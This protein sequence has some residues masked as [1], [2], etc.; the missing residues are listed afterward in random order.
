[1]TKYIISMADIPAEGREFLFSEQE[2]WLEP[3]KDYHIEAKTKTPVEGRLTVLP[4]GPKSC[5]VRGQ[6]EGQITLPCDRCNAD[7]VVTI[8]EHFD[9]Y[10]EVGDTDEAD[11]PRL[12]EEDGQVKLDAGAILWEQFLL[13]LPAKPLCRENCKGLCPKCGADLNKGDCGCETQSAD[14]RLAVLRGLKIPDKK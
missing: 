11:E 2:L 7:S 6:L 13:A 12:F 10:E 8:S 3:C 4:Q 5:L 14:P 1:M 9:V